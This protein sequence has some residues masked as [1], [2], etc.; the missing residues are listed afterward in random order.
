MK[1]LLLTSKIQDVKLEIGELRLTAIAKEIA[2]MVMSN[3]IL[4]LDKLVGS[5]ETKI[6]FL[7][8]R[9]EEMLQ[10]SRVTV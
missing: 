6:K 2:S 9:C 10:R 8:Q 3:K 4:E 1:K 7:L 5:F